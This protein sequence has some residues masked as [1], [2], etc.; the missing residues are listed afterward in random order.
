MLGALHTEGTNPQDCPE[1]VTRL[2]RT[3]SC[4]SQ[5][6]VLGV[7]LKKVRI[8]S[9]NYGATCEGR[10]SSVAREGRTEAYGQ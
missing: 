9:Q 8:S 10:A 7:G 1:L 2:E 5:E 6:M 4:A 3:G